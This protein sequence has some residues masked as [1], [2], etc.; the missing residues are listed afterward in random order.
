MSNLYDPVFFE[1]AK[2]WL[3]AISAAPALKD[4]D[5]EGRRKGLTAFLAA[6]TAGIPPVPDSQNTEFKTK[7]FDGVEITIHRFTNKQ[8]PQPSAAGG[9]AV[10]HFHGGGYILGE[11]PMFRL[12]LERKVLESGVQHFS[13][14]Y[15]L[16]PE[17]PYPTPIEDCYA[18]LIWVYEHASELGIDPARIAIMGESAGGGL[19]AGVA[20]LARD[21]KLSPPLAKQILVYPMIDARNTDPTAV[22]PEVAKHLFWSVGSNITGWTAYLGDK[23]GGSDIPV[24]ASPSLAENLEGLPPTYIDVGGLDLFRDENIE[25]AARLTKANVPVEF[26]L[27]PGL[28]HAFE[29]LGGASQPYILA[30]ANR[31]RA[32]KSL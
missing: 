20:L 17:H 22:S 5:V 18:G 25:F 4:H 14:E 27:Y 26:H 15:R 8:Q 32:A 30:Q 13:I 10:V 11:V 31:I 2:D 9:P 23:M 24:Y 3:A 1:A 16:A 28:P 19:A 29:S 12:S 21:R 6:I 7:S